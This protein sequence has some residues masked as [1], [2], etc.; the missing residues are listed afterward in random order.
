MSKK[1]EDAKEN[2]EMTKEHWCQYFIFT[3][4]MNFLNYK[5]NKKLINSFTITKIRGN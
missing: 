5:L 3:K 4:H 2:D 1:K